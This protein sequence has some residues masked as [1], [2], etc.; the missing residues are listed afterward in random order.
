M[1]GDA[2]T[3]SAFV[4]EDDDLVS[5]DSPDES[6]AL[7]Q[8]VAAETISAPTVGAVS[9]RDRPQRAWGQLLV[10]AVATF[11]L[12]V[13]VSPILRGS[14]APQRAIAPAQAHADEA[15]NDRPAHRG[16][17]TRRPTLVLPQAAR[18]TR[19]PVTGQV[20]A[21]SPAPVPAPMTRPQPQTGP[22]DPLGL[23][24]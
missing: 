12:G 19:Q 17:T 11:V 6:E 1:D 13:S 21:P 2:Q 3:T 10:A 22:T 18:G 24:S 16:R 4:I 20:A 14:S 5:L 15:T 9:D 7:V 8:P 23:G